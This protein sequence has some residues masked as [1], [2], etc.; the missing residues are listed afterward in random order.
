MNYSPN[1]D[2]NKTSF[3]Y[4]YP[5]ATDKILEKKIDKPAS[6]IEEVK[7]PHQ[8]V[9]SEKKQELT[10]TVS[11]KL[12]GKF[13]ELD[14]VKNLKSSPEHGEAVLKIQAEMAGAITGNL[15]DDSLVKKEI[16]SIK[17]TTDN[18]L[19]K[20]DHVVDK[21]VNRKSNEVLKQTDG[22]YRKS[23]ISN[24]AVSAKKEILEKPL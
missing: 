6:N 11:V 1:Y 16:S 24:I 2:V 13:D 12:A 21:E 7:S 3:L 23:D 14:V 19:N 4:S 22:D 17:S 9:L 8:A 5:Q 15:L 18:F 10:E 20:I